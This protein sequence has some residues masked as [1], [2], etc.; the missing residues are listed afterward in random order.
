MGLSEKQGNYSTT[1][2]QGIFGVYSFFFN[3]LLHFIARFITFYYHVSHGVSLGKLLFGFPPFV[4]TT[5]TTAEVDPSY[6][7]PSTFYSEPSA[8]L[9]VWGFLGISLPRNLQYPPKNHGL[10]LDP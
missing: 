1:I 5:G 7:P 6:L 8:A 4:G 3:G 2:F 9:E 10:V